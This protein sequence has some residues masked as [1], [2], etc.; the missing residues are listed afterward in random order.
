MQTR[1]VRR[2]NALRVRAACE[3]PGADLGRLPGCMYE[4]FPPLHFV[5]QGQFPV[6]LASSEL[7]RPAFGEGEWVAEFYQLATPKGNN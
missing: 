5:S 3:R 4:D 2:E 6:W 1:G 7:C